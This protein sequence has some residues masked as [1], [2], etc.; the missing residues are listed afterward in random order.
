MRPIAPLAMLLP[1]LLG[2]A[3]GVGNGA[4]GGCASYEVG[5]QRLIGGSLESARATLARMPGIQSVRVGGPNTPMTRDYRPDRA[6]VIAEGDTV[7][8][9][10]CG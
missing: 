1:L 7:R 4:S 8:S 10:T 9:I 2:C 6:T 3:G 5:F